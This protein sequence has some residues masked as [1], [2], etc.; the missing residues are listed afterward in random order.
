MAFR[1]DVTV[2]FDVNPRIV[3]IAAPSTAINIQDLYDTLRTI[4][5][6][7]YNVNRPALVDNIRTAGKQTLSTVKQVGITLALNNALL[8]F[9]DRGGPS[10]TNMEITDGNL[11]AI[12]DGVPPVFIDPVEPSS[13]INTIRELDTSAALLRDPGFPRGVGIDA[14]PITMLSSTDHITPTPGLTVSGFIK[15]DGGNYVALTNAVTEA[16]LGSYQVDITNAEM[17]FANIT[18]RFNAPGADPVSISI[19]TNV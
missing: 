12:D 10:H 3:E 9:A 6:R 16:N 5:A 13:F 14:F 2:D 8:K 17:N 4:E 7:I 18:L 19:F 15:Q 1:S 11:V